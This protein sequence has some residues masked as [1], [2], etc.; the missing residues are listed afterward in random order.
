[1]PLQVQANFCKMTKTVC[2]PVS[3]ICKEGKYHGCWSIYKDGTRMIIGKNQLCRYPSDDPFW[4][5]PKDVNFTIKTRSQ[6]RKM[7]K[8]YREEVFKY[9]KVETDEK[10]EFELHMTDEIINYVTAW[11]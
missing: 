8:P 10:K 4:K 1:M 7:N 5:K 9:F 11:Y 6:K 2:R 3:K